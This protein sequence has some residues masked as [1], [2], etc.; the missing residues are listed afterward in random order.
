MAKGAKKYIVV[1][2]L[3]GVPPWLLT[4]TEIREEFRKNP[5]F[6]EQYSVYSEKDGAVVE[7]K[8]EYEVKLVEGN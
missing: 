8:P 1:N 3:A 6:F 2:S 7:M 5:E 4:I